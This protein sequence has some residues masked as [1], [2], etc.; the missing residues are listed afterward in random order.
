MQTHGQHP[1]YEYTDTRDKLI[2]DSGEKTISKTT[3]AFVPLEGNFY[4]SYA[5]PTPVRMAEVKADEHGRLIFL[6]GDGLSY[7]LETKDKPPA[8]QP[9]QKDTFNNDDWVTTFDA[10][11][12]IIY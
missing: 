3:T 11:T 4:G 12:Y 9:D 6:A 10:C 2:I 1:T 7:A 5:D 8:D